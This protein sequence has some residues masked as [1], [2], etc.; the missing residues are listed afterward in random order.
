MEYYLKNNFG[1]IFYDFP[2]MFGNPDSAF[3][4]TTI[5]QVVPVSKVF[6]QHK[7]QFT[8]LEL[9]SKMV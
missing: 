2:K 8:A 9:D 5:L 3:R 7:I 6:F 4:K 1:L